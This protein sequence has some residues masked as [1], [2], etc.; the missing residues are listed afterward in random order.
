VKRRKLG[1]IFVWK[2]EWEQISQNPEPSDSSEYKI[3]KTSARIVST[4]ENQGLFYYELLFWTLHTKLNTVY[5]A[6]SIDIKQKE[7]ACNLYPY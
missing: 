3:N 1:P 4:I 5:A 2:Q 7:C 6:F